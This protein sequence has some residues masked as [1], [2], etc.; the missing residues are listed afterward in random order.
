MP[1]YFPPSKF[2]GCRPIKSLVSSGNTYNLPFEHWF[3]T[4]FLNLRSR[5]GMICL[6][7]NAWGV[8]V[9]IAIICVTATAKTFSWEQVIVGYRTTVVHILTTGG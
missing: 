5:C 1:S 6:A 4:A 9:K 3:A 7:L 8:V 2:F